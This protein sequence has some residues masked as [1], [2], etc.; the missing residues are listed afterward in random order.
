MYLRQQ[1]QMVFLPIKNEVCQPLSK[2]YNLSV[3]TETHPEKLKFVN[4]IP[5]HKK[6]SRILISNYRP[7]SLLSNLNMERD[8]RNY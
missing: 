2:I 1:D 4:A 5:I 7:I 8:Q 6:G 3:L